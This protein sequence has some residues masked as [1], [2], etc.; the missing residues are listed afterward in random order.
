MVARLGQKYAR[1]VGAGNFL[2]T[3]NTFPEVPGAEEIFSIERKK[4]ELAA[5]P[6]YQHQLN[7]R[8]KKNAA[9][10]I[11]FKSFEC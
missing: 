2:H 5:R 7:V 3:A 1:Q 9:I 11:L 6:S 8:T 4:A 10:L